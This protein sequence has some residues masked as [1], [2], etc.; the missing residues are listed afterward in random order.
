MIGILFFWGC[1]NLPPQGWVPTEET[2]GPV[3]LYDVT[4][5]PL[6]EIPL[7]NN[8]ATRLDPTSPTGRRVNISTEAPTAY[9]RRV[10]TVFNTLDGFG[11]FAPIMVSFDAP[12]DVADIYARHSNKD[13]RDD[14]F[15]LLN[16][17]P[18]CSRFGEEVFIDVNSGRNPLSLYKFGERIADPDAPDGEFWKEKGNLFF[19]FDSRFDQH[20]I[21]F[22]ER[23]EDK[24][25]NGILDPGE[26]LDFDGVLDVPNFIDPNACEGITGIE[27]N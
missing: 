21:L 4:A 7:P 16:V 22:E 9:E 25:Q 15:F 20:N 23:H 17:D 5:L 14:A 10:R 26:D 2:G 6:P 11:T 8:Q 24:N 13:F 27:Y 18:D 12:L 3:V 19:P 1:D